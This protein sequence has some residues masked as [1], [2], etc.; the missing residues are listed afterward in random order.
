MSTQLNHANYSRDQGYLSRTNGRI[1]IVNIKYSKFSR[2]NHRGFT[3]V[4]LLVTVLIISVLMSIA[5]PL[6]MYVLANAQKNV[7]RSNM[8]TIAN[9]VEAA[10]VKNGAADYGAWIDSNPATWAGVTGLRP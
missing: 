2:N 10:R 3:L 8:Q 6:Y 5:L 9:A 1:I 4:E 7:C